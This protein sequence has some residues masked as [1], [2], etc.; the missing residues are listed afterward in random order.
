MSNKTEYN[1]SNHI[2]ENRSNNLFAD[3]GKNNE[4]GPSIGMCPP[5]LRPPCPPGPP[6]EQGPPGEPGPQGEQG[7]PGEPGS[8]GPQ[9]EQGLPGE[10]G[11]PGPQGEQGLPGSPGPQGE[12]GLPGE[13][14]TPG[15]QGERGLPGEPGTPGEQGPPG[16]A[17]TQGEPGPQGPPGEPGGGISALP[18]LYVWK[19]NHQVLA[20]TSA[21]GA[22]GEAVTFTDYVVTGTAVAFTS[23]DTIEI[24]ESG[25]YSIRWEMYKSGYDSAFALFFSPGGADST[26]IPGSNYGAMSHDEKYSG[27]TMAYLTAGGRVTLN[28]TDTLYQLNIVEQIS[29]GTPVVGS[30]VFIVKIA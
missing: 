18:A 11:S 4:R 22:K 19:T 7:L 17:G 28:R 12:R 3:Y 30:S 15:P 24:M 27:Q 21:P 29:G 8:P 1:M 5:S 25:F 9:G 2:G 6:G 23:P 14:G 16:E 20:P 26:L 10:P 13:P